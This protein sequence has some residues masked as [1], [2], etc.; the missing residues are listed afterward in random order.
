MLAGS[1]KSFNYKVLFESLREEMIRALAEEI[2]ASAREG[3]TRHALFGGRHLGRYSGRHIYMFSVDEELRIPDGTAIVLQSNSGGVP[4]ADSNLISNASADS[5]AGS[6]GLSDP[7]FESTLVSTS[8]SPSALT[9]VSGH[10]LGTE[11]F[12]VWLG[13]EEPI[14]LMLE[15]AVAANPYFLLERLSERLQLTPCSPIAGDLFFGKLRPTRKAKTYTAPTLAHAMATPSNDERVLFVWGPPGTGKT[16]FVAEYAHRLLQQ[17][18]RVLIM[19]ISNIAVDNATIRLSGQVTAS[20]Q[21]A[22]PGKNSPIVRYGHPI[23]P[24]LRDDPT[25]VAHLM[26]GERHPDLLEERQALVRK[27][28]ELMATGKSSSE[29]AAREFHRLT[30]EIATIDDLLAEEERTIA[31]SADV[32][33]TTLAKASLAGFVQPPGNIP[34]ALPYDVVILDEASIIGLPYIL[35][36]SSLAKK[37]IVIVGDFRQL[38]PVVRSSSQRAKQYLHRDIFEYLSIPQTV[39]SGQWDPRLH[40][41]H[42]Q[43]RMDPAISRLVSASVYNGLLQDARLVKERKPGRYLPGLDHPALIVDTSSFNPFCLKDPSGKSQSRFNILNALLGILLVQ[44]TG[45]TAAGIITPYVLQ[46]R[47]ANRMVLELGM[48]D[49]VACSTV[50]RFQGSERQV[51]I[52]DTVDSTGTRYAGQLIQ[53]GHDS[54]AMRLLNVAI[55]RAREKLIIVANIKWLSPRLAGDNILCEAFDTLPV[56]DAAELIRGAAAPASLQM[57]F[58][59]HALPPQAIPSAQGTPP[60]QVVPLQGDALFPSLIQAI[61]GARDSIRILTDG[62]GIIP[63]ILHAVFEASRKSIWEPWVQGHTDGAGSQHETPLSNLKVEVGIY[64]NAPSEVISPDRVKRRLQDRPLQSRVVRSSLPGVNVV[65]I[66]ETTMFIDLAQPESSSTGPAS[67]TAIR[68]DLPNTV[69]FINSLLRTNPARSVGG[70][71]EILGRFRCPECNNRMRV[72]P[73]P[74]SYFLGCARYPLCSGKRQIEVH[75]VQAH[76]NAL[77][78]NSPLTTCPAC[79]SPMVARSGRRGVFLSCSSYPAC[80]QTKGLDVLL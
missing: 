69:P 28:K 9:E 29:G 1:L 70:L 67:H 37:R 57:T 54:I 30:A 32:L 21:P 35:W 64:K 43:F 50:H 34:D 31:E 20:N 39:D 45:S 60:Y 8:P 18:E 76:I 46:G 68:V 12:T 3:G 48:E 23:H 71:A 53:G 74:Y 24:D 19:S 33:L 36:S 4:H 42:R 47:L 56:I 44:L 59:G 63:A 51:I 14:D 16:Q 26:A 2:L 11:G 77:T 55:T 17:G 7:E 15:W 66:D 41:L 22:S 38:P 72:V 10:L 25:L 75:W 27:R 5:G 62:K 78:V 49:K 52:L 58:S 65:I 79:D 6:A 80:K 13:L 40:I 73:G 61:Q